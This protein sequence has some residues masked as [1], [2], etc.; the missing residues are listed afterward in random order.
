MHVLSREKRQLQLGC[1]EAGLHV[2]E[3]GKAVGPRWLACFGPNFMACKWAGLYS[4]WA[5][6]MGP[7][8]DK[9][10]LGFGPNIRP[11]I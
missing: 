3:K 6:K 7:K 5:P 8:M 9:M 11:M 2:G 10:G 4:C 1:L